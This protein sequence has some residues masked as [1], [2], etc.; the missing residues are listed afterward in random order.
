[1]KFSLFTLLVALF[2]AYAQALAKPVSLKTVIVTF[3]D[4][5]PGHIMQQA[6]DAIVEAGGRITHE[7]R[8]IKG[9][10]ALT[11]DKVLQSVSTQSLEYM[12]VYEED[13]QMS[14]NV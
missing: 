2:C 1:M 14:I 13:Q 9:F 4:N 5:T 7:Y 12:P 11:S 6:K 3:P 10:S 8:I